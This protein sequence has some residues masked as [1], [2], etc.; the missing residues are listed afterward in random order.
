MQTVY[1]NAYHNDPYSKELGIKISEKLTS[2]EARFL[3]P[4][5]YPG[6]KSLWAVVVTLVALK[7]FELVYEKIPATL[8]TDSTIAALMK[9]VKVNVVIIGA[10]C[11]TANKI[12][13]YNLVVCLMHHSIP[14][15]VAAPLTSID[16]SFSLV[17]EIIIEERSP[18]ELLNSRGGLG[19]QVAAS[20]IFVWN[21]TFDVTPASLISGIIT[22][23]GVITKM[24]TDDFNTEDFI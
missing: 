16:S 15:Y 19:E 24:G 18:K 7:A 9:E 8:T 3:P 22:E 17:K 11:D 21:P 12:G 5:G 4:Y 1:H 2:V 13:T 20:R 6:C 23:K 10:D 14:L